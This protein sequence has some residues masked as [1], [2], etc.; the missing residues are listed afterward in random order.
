IE[1]YFERTNA[2]V[3]RG[4]F[5]AQG[6]VIEVMPTNEKESIIRMVLEGGK[7]REL[8]LLDPITRKIQKEVLDVWIFP[9]KH[10]VVGGDKFEGAMKSIESELK[11]RLKE[12]DKSGKILEAE[13]LKRRTRYDLQ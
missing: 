3:L 10:Y 11:E 5:R 12:L 9:A 2:D 4:T 7:V 8:F 6:D 13:R 1:I